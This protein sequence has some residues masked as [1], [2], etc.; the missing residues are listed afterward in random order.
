MKVANRLKDTVAGDPN[1]PQ[2]TQTE[3]A[4]QKLI[5]QKRSSKKNKEDVEQDEREDEYPKI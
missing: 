3:Q 5:L 4:T 1:I 2:E